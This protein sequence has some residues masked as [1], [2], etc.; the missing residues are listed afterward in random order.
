MVLNRQI[1]DQIL[2][3]VLL[4][5]TAAPNEKKRGIMRLANII[6][7]TFFSR[8]TIILA[9]W[10]IT[11]LICIQVMIS[12]TL[13][14]AASGLVGCA[15]CYWGAAAYMGS[16]ARR[17]TAMGVLAV[18]LIVAGQALISRLAAHSGHS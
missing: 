1:F 17:E 6:T 12:G 13:L 18:I 10:L 15:L 16:L 4:T 2:C 8:A 3:D 5:P 9:Y 14:T 7:Y 11:L